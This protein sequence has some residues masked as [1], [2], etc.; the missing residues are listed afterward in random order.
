MT[1]YECLRISTF[2]H[3]RVASEG[4]GEL[5]RAPR[6]RVERQPVGVRL[7]PSRPQGVDRDRERSSH[8]RTHLCFAT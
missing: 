1:I 2:Q 4:R 5:D 3:Q 8:H 7:P 6:D